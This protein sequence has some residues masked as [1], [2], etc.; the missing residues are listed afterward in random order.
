MAIRVHVHVFHFGHMCIPIISSFMMSVIQAAGPAA[1]GNVN[2][3]SLFDHLV[4]SDI[5]KY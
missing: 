3:Q 4:D 1:L 2:S 5:A